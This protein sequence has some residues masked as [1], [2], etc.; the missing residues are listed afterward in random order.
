LRSVTQYDPAARVTSFHFDAVGNL[1]GLTDP[2]GNTIV[3]CYDEANRVYEVVQSSSSP[4]HFKR[5]RAGRVIEMTD[6]NGAVTKYGYDPL[7]RLVSLRE[8]GWPA[9]APMNAGK[10]LTIAYDPKGKRLRVSDSEAAGDCL[11]HYDP[12]GNLV[13][14]D[15]PDGFTLL[16]DYDARNALVRVHDGASAVDLRFTLDGDGRLL[17]L[18]DSAYL[19]PARTYTY[20]RTAGT[21]VDNLYGIDYDASMIATRFEYDPNRQLTLATHSLTRATLASY[22]YAYRADG[23][24]GSQ[25]GTRPATYDYDDREQLTREG[26]GIRDGY[27]AAGNRLWRAATPPPVAQQA[28][29]DAQNRMLS[30]GHGI[31][32][33]YDANGNLLKRTPPGGTPTVYT[34]DG[35]NRLRLVDDGVTVVRYSYDAD[36]RMI[37]RTS[38]RGTRTDTRGYRYSNRSILAELDARGN[39]A[40]LYTR[41]DGGRLLRRRS[42]TALTPRPSQD[43]HSLFYLSDGL[44]N[45]VRLVDWDGKPHLSRNYDAWGGSAGSGRIGTFGYRSGYEDSYTKL[46]NFGAR[47]YDPILGRWLSPDP[48]L[49]VMTGANS[50]VLPHHLEL[51]NLYR[52]VSNNPLNLWDPTG[53]GPIHMLQFERDVPVIRIPTL[54][55]LEMR[56]NQ[57]NFEPPNPNVS[58]I[59]PSKEIYEASDL[60]GG[61]FFGAVAYGWARL[62]GRSHEAAVAAGAAAN[63]AFSIYNRELGVS[64]YSDPVYTSDFGKNLEPPRPQGVTGFAGRFPQFDYRANIPPPANSR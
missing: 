35:A 48:L 40:V 45:I 31:T 44:G 60:L 20:H 15:D 34:Y 13:E 19:D 21:L 27:D 29:F 37:E 6:R 10:Q 36:G 3:I 63:I 52:Y 51:T 55:E 50:D 42:R 18:T 2:A 12:A 57:S 61:V 24:V 39:I 54:E 11:Y 30:D 53:L 28:V 47:W 43:P 16:F 56:L 33:D 7:G 64:G 26:P 38:Q 23:L 46:V 32:Y 49:P 58:N 22:G 62:R 1:T 41:D 14:R 17:A 59:S 8:P 4:I 25:A 9:S 5:D